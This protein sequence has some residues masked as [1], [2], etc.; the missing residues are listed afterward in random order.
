MA[1]DDNGAIIGALAEVVGKGGCVGV[2]RGQPKRADGER[3]HRR[4]QDFGDF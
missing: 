4:S 3:E 1:A 2:C